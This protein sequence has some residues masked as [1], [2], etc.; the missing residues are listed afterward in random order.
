[1]FGSALIYLVAII[2]ESSFRVWGHGLIDAAQS[3]LSRV[4][5]LIITLSATAVRNGS[6]IGD[7]GVAQVG[8]S[9]GSLAAAGVVV[10]RTWCNDLLYFICSNCGAGVSSWGDLFARVAML[11]VFPFAGVHDRKF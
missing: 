8:F 1:M 11:S 9:V 2:S 4:W 6:V 7:L 5:Q 3:W 10:R